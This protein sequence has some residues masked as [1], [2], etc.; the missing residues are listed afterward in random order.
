MS[1]SPTE[2]HG[3]IE[4]REKGRSGV[5][6]G[7]WLL[8]MNL[9]CQKKVTCLVGRDECFINQAKSDFYQPEVAE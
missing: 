2:I 3:S 1:L 6:D 4:V 5:Q 9:L 8:R 7:I